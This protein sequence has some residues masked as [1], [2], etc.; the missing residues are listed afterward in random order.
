MFAGYTDAAGDAEFGHWDY[1]TPSPMQASAEYA[2]MYG[3][4]LYAVRLGDGTIKIGVTG[5]LHLRLTQL[6]S[7]TQ[8]EPEVLA[9]R[10]GTI[11]DERALHA[12]LTEHLDHGREWYRPDPEVLAIV[13]EWRSALHM[14]PVA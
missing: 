3:T 11:E 4:I 10:N 5:H 6:R 13:N 9:V 2:E 8:S 14:E 12:S 7:L 1:G